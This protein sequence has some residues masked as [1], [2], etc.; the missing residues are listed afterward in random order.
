MSITNLL[1]V[2]SI[3]MHH[4]IS[5]AL[6]TWETSALCPS[7]L[8]CAS[9]DCCP[10]Q[11]NPAVYSTGAEIPSEN[12]YRESEQAWFLKTQFWRADEL[13]A[14]FPPQPHWQVR[15]HGKGK[16]AK[17][18]QRLLPLILPVRA[19]RAIA[20]FYSHVYRH[21]QIFY[22]KLHVHGRAVV[23]VNRAEHILGWQ[24]V[25]K[26]H[27]RS[28]SVLPPCKATMSNTQEFREMLQMSWEF[29]CNTKHPQQARYPVTAGGLSDTTSAGKS[30]RESMQN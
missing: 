1:V 24:Q 4:R 23:K 29:Q 28:T 7:I 21:F 22:V 6:L 11:A 9:A 12:G 8:P 27:L 3:K 17:P 16:G 10:S 25:I 5:V 15:Q 13:L 14:C 30:K 2:F 20:H 26:L 19:Q 18:R